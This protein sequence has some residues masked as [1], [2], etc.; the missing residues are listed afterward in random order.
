M[1]NWEKTKQNY[2]LCDIQGILLKISH[3]IGFLIESSQQINKE[4]TIIPLCSD[5]NPEAKRDRVTFSRSHQLL[6]RAGEV[7]IYSDKM[8]N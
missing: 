1:R 7:H 6:N 3:T 4:G 2:M 8:Q 5:E